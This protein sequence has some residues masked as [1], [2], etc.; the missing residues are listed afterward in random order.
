MTIHISS[1]AIEIWGGEVWRLCLR[2]AKYNAI[3]AQRRQ[4]LV[5]L[6][7]LWDWGI[8]SSRHVLIF[9]LF[10]NNPDVICLRQSATVLIDLLSLQHLPNIFYCR[11]FQVPFPVELNDR[12]L[13]GNNH[14]F[15]VRKFI[16]ESSENRPCR[17]DSN[18]KWNCNSLR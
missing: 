16:D 11:Q 15:V 18:Q 9:L 17:R 1:T 5:A 7:S 12:K 13:R 6:E 3:I 2:R 8:R 14:P 10:E 4:R